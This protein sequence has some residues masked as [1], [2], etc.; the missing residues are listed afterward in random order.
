MFSFFGRLINYS[1]V[2]FFLFSL[3]VLGKVSLAFPWFPQQLYFAQPP[4]KSDLIVFLDGEYQERVLRAFELYDQGYAKK[5]FSP[6]IKVYANKQ[7]VLRRRKL[8]GKD[9]KF[10]EGPVAASTYEEAL[11]TKA[12]VQKYHLKSLILV[13]SSYHSYRAY[14]IFTKLMPDITIT[15]CPVTLEKSWF[16]FDRANTDPDHRKI[17]R[18]E[19]LKFLGYYLKYNFGLKVDHKIEKQLRRDLTKQ[20]EVDYLH[21]IKEFIGNKIEQN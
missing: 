8:M 12:F 9:L 1:I 20:D 14:W 5:I 18:S 3:Y 13:T 10:Y 17:V 2:A 4:Q 15:S 16:K 21:Y 11:V 6:N 19:Q 7:V